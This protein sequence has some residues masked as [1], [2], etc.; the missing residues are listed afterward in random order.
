MP[1]ARRKFCPHAARPLRINCMA[2][3]TRPENAAVSQNSS[4]R[5]R[6]FIR[7]NIEEDNV[8]RKGILRTVAGLPTVILLALVATTIPAKTP[9]P[10]DN[11]K[12]HDS[13]RSRMAEPKSGADGIARRAKDARFGDRL[14]TAVDYALPWYSFNGGGIVSGGSSTNGLGNTI[15]QS[16]AGRGSSADYGLEFG[17]LAGA[18]VCNCSYQGDYDEDGFITA[19]DLGSMIDILYAGA[20]DVQDRNCPTTRLDSQCDG[21]PDALDLGV[22]VDYIFAGGAPPCEPCTDM[23]K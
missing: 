8:R 14:A 16:F 13:L 20:Q 5:Y 12:T 18:A 23:Q 9:M 4:K 2:R 15:G 3:A 7:I 6:R 22:W 11:S 10:A 1:V 21:F 19:L 17:F